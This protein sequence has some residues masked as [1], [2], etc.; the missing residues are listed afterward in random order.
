LIGRLP[1]KSMSANVYLIVAITE[2]IA[3]IAITEVM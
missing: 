2:V 1:I 3:R